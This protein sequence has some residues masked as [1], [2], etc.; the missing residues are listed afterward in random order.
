[1]MRIPQST[2][3]CHSLPGHISLDECKILNQ[4][5]DGKETPRG[6]YSLNH[7][8]GE[9]KFTYHHNDNR[10]QGDD[11]E[12]HRM[13]WLMPK[14]ARRLTKNSKYHVSQWRQ[15]VEVEASECKR[16]LTALESALG[17][18]AEANKSLPKACHNIS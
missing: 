12:H 9:D 15:P 4:I 18:V 14:T 1:M 13:S 3:N 7:I 6:C 2:S 5:L 11:V 10:F 16:I 8:S 17:D